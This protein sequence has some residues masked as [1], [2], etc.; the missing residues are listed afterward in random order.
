M[1]SEKNLRKELDE[2]E[3]QI[4]IKGKYLRVRVQ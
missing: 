1:M 2:S 3:L 4:T